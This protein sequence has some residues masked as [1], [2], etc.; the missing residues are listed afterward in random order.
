MQLLSR[1][2]IDSRD[3]IAI[4]FLSIRSVS[5]ILQKYVGF[6]A[7]VRYLRDMIG[8]EQTLSVVV[9]TQHTKK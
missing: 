7:M 4:H 2:V 5:W 6:N 8:L 3:K 1:Y 9:V